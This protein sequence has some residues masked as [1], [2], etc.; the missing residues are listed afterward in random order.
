MAINFG[1]KIN[2]P[3][4]INIDENSMELSSMLVNSIPELR[5]CIGC[6]SCTGTCS[7]G[8]LTN[9]NFRKT[10]TLFRRGEYEG[11]REEMRKCMLCGKCILVCPRGIN[12]RK[13]IFKIRELLEK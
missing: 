2:K 6:G 10:Q 8:N 12:T 3:R 13:V 7:A 1:Y 11:V 9:F 5:S 4:V